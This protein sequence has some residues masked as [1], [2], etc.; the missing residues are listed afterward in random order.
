MSKEQ[1]FSEVFRRKIREILDEQVD[2]NINAEDL[3]FDLGMRY[4]RMMAAEKKKQ[5]SNKA[6]QLSLWVEDAASKKA[7]VDYVNTV[8]D[9]HSPDFIPTNDRIAVFDLDGTVYCES[10]PKLVRYLVIS[11]NPARQGTSHV[12][13]RVVML[14]K[15]TLYLEFGAPSRAIKGEKCRTE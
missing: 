6:N 10:D 8:T 9:K 7:L 5:I 15:A 12:R 11:A 14:A 4:L 1:E 3:M 2:E 13:S